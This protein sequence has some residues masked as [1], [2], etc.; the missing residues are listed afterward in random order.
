MQTHPI[1]QADK[2]QHAALLRIC[3]Q[4]GIPWVVA[5]RC[6]W[7]SADGATVG[8]TMRAGDYAEPVRFTE[9]GHHAPAP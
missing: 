8:V 5:I 3:A 4:L 1:D 9:G 6:A 2:R 7:V